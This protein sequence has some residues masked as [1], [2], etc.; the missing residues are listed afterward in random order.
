MTCTKALRLC[1]W[2][3]SLGILIRFPEKFTCFLAT[4]L[5]PKTC[6]PCLQTIGLWTDH[7]TSLIWGINPTSKFSPS[8]AYVTPSLMIQPGTFSFLHFWCIWLVGWLFQI[9]EMLRNRKVNLAAR[10]VWISF[11][12]VWPLTSI[13]IYP[14]SCFLDLLNG[15][16]ATNASC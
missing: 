14:E 6:A 16:N 13:P 8:V 1:S 9:C 4:L 5:G 7:W 11:L 10:Q 2:S 12:P 3:V 15:N